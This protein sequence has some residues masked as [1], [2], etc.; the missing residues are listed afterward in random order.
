[1]SE[2]RV[3]DRGDRERDCPQSLQQRH[4]DPDLSAT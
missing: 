1:M 4:H 3:T 2:K